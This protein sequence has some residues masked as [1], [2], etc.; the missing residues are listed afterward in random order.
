MR[1]EIEVLEVGE[2]IL[3]LCNLDKEERGCKKG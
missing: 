3:S 2:V 1:G